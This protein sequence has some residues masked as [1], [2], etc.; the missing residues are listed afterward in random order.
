[1]MLSSP[2]WAAACTVSFST[3]ANTQ[4]SYVFTSGNTSSCDPFLIG[5]AYDSAGDANSSTGPVFN[6]ATLQGGTIAIYNGS[7]PP[8]GDPN[9]NGFVYTPPTNFSGTDTA[10]F[11]TS[12]DGS[13]GCPTARCPSR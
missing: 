8:S 3:T 10:T 13:P 2:A 9:T 7:V 1:M 12:N 5:I 6:T 4:K 11:Y